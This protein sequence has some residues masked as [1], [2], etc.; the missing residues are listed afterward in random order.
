MMNWK[1][2]RIA[3]IDCAK[4]AA[5]VGVL[6]DHTNGILY[7][8]ADIAAASYYSVSL[9]ILLTGISSYIENAQIPAQNAWGG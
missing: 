4:F 6:I 5:I 3:W 8:N 1:R 2:P 7:R 9:F